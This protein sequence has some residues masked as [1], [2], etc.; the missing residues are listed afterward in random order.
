MSIH[1]KNS[2]YRSNA[3]HKPMN[4]PA[5]TGRMLFRQL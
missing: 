2:G 5:A 3:R 1:W 4:N